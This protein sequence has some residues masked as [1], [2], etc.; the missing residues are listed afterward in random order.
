MEAI[1]RK[2]IPIHYDKEKEILYFDQIEE[3]NSNNF[4][5]LHESNNAWATH[6]I[7][8][9]ILKE[10]EGESTKLIRL[11]RNLKKKAVSGS[12]EFGVPIEVQYNDLNLK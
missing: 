4:R 11:V 10:F 7:N 9:N 5:F 3:F 8:F 6:E 1:K 12:I 2:T